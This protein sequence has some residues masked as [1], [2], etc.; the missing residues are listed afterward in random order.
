[1]YKIAELCTD[2][3]ARCTINS[4]QEN[5]LLLDGKQDQLYPHSRAGSDSKKPIM[6]RRIHFDNVLMASKVSEITILKVIIKKQLTQRMHC[7]KIHITCRWR[8][9]LFVRNFLAAE[10]GLCQT[11]RQQGREGLIEQG[12][13]DMR[14]KVTLRCNEC[15]QRNY[16]TFKNKKNTPDRLEMNKYCPFCRKHTL[17]SETK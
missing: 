9:L 4:V 15:K 12:G 14:V 10:R 1:M 16:D 11:G 17:H 13:A 2:K 7:A 6:T 5:S 8:G 3:M